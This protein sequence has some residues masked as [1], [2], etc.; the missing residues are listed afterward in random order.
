MGI[1]DPNIKVRKAATIALSSVLFLISERT[2]SKM[3]IYHDIYSH[4]KD[5]FESKNV[6]HIHGCLLALGE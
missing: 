2:F 6:D 4:I 1:K 3:T 5:V